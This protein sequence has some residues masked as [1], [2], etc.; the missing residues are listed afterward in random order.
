MDVVRVDH[1]RHNALIQV[2]D[3]GHSQRVTQ[4]KVS[5][6]ALRITAVDVIGGDAVALLFKGVVCCGSDH[7]HIVPRLLERNSQAPRYDACTT[8]IF[9]RYAIRQHH[10]AQEI[11]ARPQ[12]KTHAMGAG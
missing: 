2:V 12:A 3:V 1:I 9:G 4:R 10:N 5:T 7:M 8:A 11:I 6:P